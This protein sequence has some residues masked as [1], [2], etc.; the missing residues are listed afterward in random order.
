MTPELREVAQ[1]L[2]DEYGWSALDDRA[3]IMEWLGD[4]GLLSPLDAPDHRA[5]EDA[6]HEVESHARW[7]LQ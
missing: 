3:R 6:A 4:R 5:D 7:L 1:L 2:V